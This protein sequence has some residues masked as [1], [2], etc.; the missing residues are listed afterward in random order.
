MIFGRPAGIRTQDYRFGD[1]RFEAAATTGLYVSTFFYLVV[2]S[3][4][5]AGFEPV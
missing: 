2:T 5:P 4:P 1:D 3:A